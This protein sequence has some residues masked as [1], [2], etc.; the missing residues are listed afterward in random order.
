MALDMIVNT[1][2]LIIV[3]GKF[4]LHKANVMSI[5][6]FFNFFSKDLIIFHD[7][8]N[9]ITRNKKCSRN[10]KFPQYLFVLCLMLNV[11]YKLL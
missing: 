10:N 11:H 7:S 3:L 5:T 9:S 1:L 2:K 4:H 8:L 6:P